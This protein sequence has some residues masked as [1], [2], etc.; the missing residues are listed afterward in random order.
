[1]SRMPALLPGFTPLSEVEN[2]VDATVNLLGVV[3]DTR[4]PTMS[5]GSGT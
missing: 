3:A 5:A 4:P 2:R 1:M